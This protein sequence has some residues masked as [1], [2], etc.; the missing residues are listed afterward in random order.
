MCIEYWRWPVTF[1]ICSIS[2]NICVQSSHNLY[3]TFSGMS[4]LPTIVTLGFSIFCPAWKP[5]TTD[6]V[7]PSLA[8]WAHH[9]RSSAQGRVGWS[10]QQEGS[11]HEKSTRG[12]SRSWWHWSGSRWS[13]SQDFGESPLKA[14]QKHTRYSGKNP[15]TGQ[16]TR[17][18][19]SKQNPQRSK[20]VS[21]MWP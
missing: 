19:A 6:G 20:H 15:G 21:A 12:Q 2:A 11:W 17:P 1:F 9:Q 10:W 3:L 14:R 18:S 13:Y 5:P 16:M 8:D 7:V 4:L